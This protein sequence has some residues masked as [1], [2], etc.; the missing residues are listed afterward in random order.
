MGVKEGMKK[1]MDPGGLLVISAILVIGL[2]G[3]C[4]CRM[5]KSSEKCKFVSVCVMCMILCVCV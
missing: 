5:F 3:E 4:Y 2:L 1:I